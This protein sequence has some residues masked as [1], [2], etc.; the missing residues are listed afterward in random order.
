M[1]T[2]R[3]GTNGHSQQADQLKP[4]NP[5]AEE[6]ALGS[7]LIDRDRIIEV[8]TFLKPADFFIESN[9]WIY[10]TILD[11]HNAG[12]P[13][14][15]V[16]LSDE[17]QRR[18]YLDG[19]GGPA[20]ITS[21]INATPTSIHAEYYSRIVE[22]TGTMR[23]LIQAA[24]DIARLAYSDQEDT[25]L[26]L[27]KAE[28]LVSNVSQGRGVKKSQHISSAVSEICDDVEAI[29]EA[30]GKKILG[31]PTGL[32]DMDRM[33][34]GLQRQALHIFA[35]R[36]GMGKT[37][38]ALQMA[39]TAA[40]RFKARSMIFSL[41]MGAKEL[42]RRLLAAESGIEEKK[43]KAGQIN[44]NEEWERYFQALKTVNDWPIY[45]DDDGWLTP[46][47]MRAR[48]IRQNHQTGLDLIIVDYIQ[49]MGSDSRRRDNRNQEMSEISRACKLLAKEINIPVVALSQLSRQCESRHDKRPV[50]S[51]LRDS[52]AIEADADVVAFIYRDEIYNPNTEFP[53]VAEI[54]VAKHRSGPTGV[55][56]VYYRKH[57]TE[58]IDLEVRTTSL[59]Y[60]GG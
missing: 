41:E 21:L 28:S 36:P 25:D 32:T 22:R 53:N 43:I 1:Q 38:L 19:I 5:D 44:T 15:I 50:L 35:G 16:T 14:D 3:N 57:L 39:R 33:L 60:T 27:A 31:L 10:E 2:Y 59:D 47:Q 46:S 40:R 8:S 6:A 12:K 56:S 51:D 58:F 55:F 26:I 4:H 52:G 48:A 30:G 37:S 7:L 23:R 17:L 42:T 29:K 18:G 13:A 11:L 9:G 45:I 24:G 49:L 20:R 34:G 54:I